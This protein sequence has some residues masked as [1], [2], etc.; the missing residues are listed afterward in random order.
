M[1]YLSMFLE[2]RHSQEHDR[3]NPAAGHGSQVSSALTRW[4]FC[5][6]KGQGIKETALEISS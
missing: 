4:I 6:P 1:A 3:G 5:D 2:H